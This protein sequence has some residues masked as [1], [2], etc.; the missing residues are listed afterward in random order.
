MKNKKNMS[1]ANEPP[2]GDQWLPK[3]SEACP[4]EDTFSPGGKTNCN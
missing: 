4:N 1:V 3:W 2:P